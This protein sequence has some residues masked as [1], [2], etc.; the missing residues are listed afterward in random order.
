MTDAEYKAIQRKCQKYI[1]IWKS[2][3][4]LTQWDIR[5]YYHREPSENEAYMSVTP[6][7]RYLMA[8]FHVHAWD[9]HSQELDDTHIERCVVHEL[10]HCLLDEMNTAVPEDRMEWHEN[11]VERTVSTLTNVLYTTYSEAA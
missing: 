7:W 2:R 11:H 8:E 6:D 10:C 1:G 3:I 5:T 9:I 4:W